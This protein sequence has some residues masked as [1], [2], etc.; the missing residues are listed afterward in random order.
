MFFSWLVFNYVSVLLCVIN[1][2]TVCVCV[3]GMDREMVFVCVCVSVTEC[4]CMC[5]VL[6][7]TNVA[8]VVFT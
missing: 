2:G 6:V 1:L 7:K 8:Y 4:V 3:R 5:V